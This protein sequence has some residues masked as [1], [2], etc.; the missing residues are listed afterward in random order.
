MINL[1]HRFDIFNVEGKSK[2][3]IFFRE[4]MVGEN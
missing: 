4:L 3:E 2:I 1:W